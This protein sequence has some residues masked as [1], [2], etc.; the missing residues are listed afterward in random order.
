Q[1][2]LLSGSSAA[3][4]RV[5]GTRDAGRG[6]GVSAVVRTA[7]QVAWGRLESEG[8]PEAGGLRTALLDIDLGFGAL[9][10]GQDSLRPLLVPISP[11]TRVREEPAGT[12]VRLVRRTLESE[13][14]LKTFIDITCLKPH[15][16]PEFDQVI[17]E[18][19]E[20]LRVGGDPS[21]ICHAVLGRFR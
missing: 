9:R 14:G 20:R 1:P 16:H 12:G 3:N 21:A 5:G 17:A 2:A 10:L 8:P 15:L 19:I 11:N 7:L 18:V 4:P 6:D 13:E